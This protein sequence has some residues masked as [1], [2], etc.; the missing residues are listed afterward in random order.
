MKDIKIIDNCVID[1]SL[2]NK[3]ELINAAN[4]AVEKYKNLVITD[5]DVPEI[6]KVN[7]D[8]RKL[9]K[10]LDDTRKKAIAPLSKAAK[11][12]KSEIDEVIAVIEGE[13]SNLDSQV[14]A[15]EEQERVKKQEI[16][17]ELIEEVCEFIGVKPE[18]IDFVYS[19]TNK[20][21][22]LKQVKNDI[23][24][25]AKQ[26]AEADALVAE[27]EKLRL[28]MIETVEAIFNT[29]KSNYVFDL[30]M[31]K[32]LDG[33]KTPIELTNIIKQDFEAE[34][35]RLE[36][37]TREAIKEKVPAMERAITSSYTLTIN[38]T[39]TVMASTKEEAQD[40]AYQ[41]IEPSMFKLD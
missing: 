14:K 22:S 9:I 7:A 4:E 25:Q 6:K 11:D 2:E 20:T 41:E 30:P 3:E 24:V 38:Q 12:F 35:L 40:L 15:F 32:Y 28:Q 33:S 36:A 27:R 8:F 1:L 29:V 23:E 37:K 19:W 26:I 18:R 17:N 39:F 13:V 16:I 21:T 31:A 34:K 10:S 5:A